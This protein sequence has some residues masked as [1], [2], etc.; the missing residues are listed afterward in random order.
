MLAALVC[1]LDPLLLKEMD[2]ALRAKISNPQV[3]DT[4]DENSNYVVAK[5]HLK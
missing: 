4:L 1:L 2:P 5:V 3:L